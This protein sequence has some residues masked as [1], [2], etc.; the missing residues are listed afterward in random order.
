MK[1]TAKVLPIRE[2]V[3]NMLR[4]GAEA[5]FVR[6]VYGVELTKELNKKDADKYP[7]YIPEDKLAIIIAEAKDKLNREQMDEEELKWWM[8]I[9]KVSY[10]K[11]PEMMAKMIHEFYFMKQALD[12]IESIKV[13]QLP[14]STVAKVEIPG[15]LMALLKGHNWYAGFADS[16]TVHANCD[17]SEER[18]LKYIG[19]NNELREAALEYGKSQGEYAGFNFLKKKF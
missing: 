6:E 12:T 18:I 5:H 7:I 1:I 19:D 9:F 10:N 3:L 16:S 4:A 2:C 17:I 11:F 13:Y 8:R 15:D 14:P